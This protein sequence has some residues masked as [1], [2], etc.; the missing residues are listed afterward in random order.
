VQS[1]VPLVCFV[2]DWALVGA[3]KRKPRTIVGASASTV[4]E[5]AG[6]VLARKLELPE[7]RAVR[8]CCPTG[9]DVE[10][11][12]ATPE[13]FNVAVP[14]TVDPFRKVTVP[15]GMVAPSVFTVAVRPTGSP[16]I[17]ALV[18]AATLVDVDL[19]FAP[20]VTSTR[21]DLLMRELVS[22]AY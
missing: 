6:D 8:S 16:T 4:T 12:F 3:F 17:T 21:V 11:S 18:E 15:V 13:D 19:A 10:D 20:T 22:P 2:S 1:A 7:N 5:T 14:R 9:S